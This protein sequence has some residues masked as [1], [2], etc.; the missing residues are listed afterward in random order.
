[1]ERPR[2]LRRH[3]WRRK[4]EDQ[5]SLGFDD[6]VS[7]G[8]LI[9]NYSTGGSSGHSTNHRAL[10]TT[11]HHSAEHGAGSGSSTDLRRFT[12]S[13]ATSLELTRYWL[14]VSLHRL[15]ATAERDS[16]CLQGQPSLR[17]LGIGGTDPGNREADRCS[18]CDE[19]LPPRSGNILHDVSGDLLPN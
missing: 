2:V 8:R 13:Y 12:S 3:Q 11:T 9:G 15:Y 7:S 17:A 5:R 16:V 6:H 4:S 10:G 18:C 1:M 19:C 14:N